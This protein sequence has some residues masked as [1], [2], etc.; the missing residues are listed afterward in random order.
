MRNNP[1]ITNY[2]LKIN[3]FTQIVYLNSINFLINQ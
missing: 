3:K 1:F 2:I